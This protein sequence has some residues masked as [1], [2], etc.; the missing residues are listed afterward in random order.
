MWHCELVKI[1]VQ[2]LVP[3]FRYFLRRELL[4]AT[5]VI[6]E[7]YWILKSEF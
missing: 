2:K 3:A 6:L 7:E 1:T 5:G 4:K